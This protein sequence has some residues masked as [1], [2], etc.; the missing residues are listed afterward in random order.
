MRC[1]VSLNSSHLYHKLSS[2]D[3]AVTF[4]HFAIPSSD[5]ESRPLQINN[6][7]PPFRKFGVASAAED[8]TPFMSPSRMKYPFKRARLDSA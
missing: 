4:L 6:L 5:Q 1:N 3:L 8:S 2:P 7:V